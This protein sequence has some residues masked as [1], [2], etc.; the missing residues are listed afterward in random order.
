MERKYQPGIIC[1]ARL[2]SHR[3]PNKLLHPIHDEKSI[4]RH[5]VLHH[6]NRLRG[7]PYPLVVAMPGKFSNHGL[8]YFL[9]EKGYE[10]FSIEQNEE[11]VLFRFLE[12]A[13]KYR[14]DPIIRTCADSALISKDEI[15]DTLEK[16]YL[17]GRGWLAVGWGVQ[18]ISLRA[19]HWAHM[20]DARMES[21]EHVW[22]RLEMSINYPEDISSAEWF[23]KRDKLPKA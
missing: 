12:C 13:K 2:T 22:S 4:S 1:Q 6:L 10:T 23:L 7:L 20:N 5:L 8:D 3:F 15:V 17:R 18:I 16:Y 14:F 9:K 11:D 19:L 21:R